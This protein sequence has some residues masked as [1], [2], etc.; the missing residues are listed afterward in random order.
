[1][2]LVKAL[3]LAAALGIGLGGCKEKLP[4]AEAT[5]PDAGAPSDSAVTYDFG[6]LRAL[7][8]AGEWKTEGVVVLHDGQVVYE[9]Y[10]AGFDASMRHITYSAS[11]SVGSALVGIAVA[12]GVIKL[13]ESVC[14]YVAPPAGS[15]PSLCDTTIEELLQM[16]SG[17]GWAEDYGAN[18]T[19]SNVLQMLYGNQQDMGAYV[20][21]QPRVAKAGEVWSYSSGDANLLARALRGALAGTDMRAWAKEKLFDPA[22]LTSA[23]F[24]SDRSGTLVF[25]SSCFMTPRDMARFGQLYL[26][27]GMNGSTRVLPAGWVAYTTT[28]ARPVATPRSRVADAAPGDTGGSYGASFWLNA[29]SPSAPQDTW[30]YPD[31]P[32]DAYSAEGHW[33]QKIFVVP[34][35]RLVI[36][37]VGNDRDKIFDS[38]PMVGAAVA[39]IDRGGK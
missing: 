10:A 26:D 39:S 23:I 22:G 34:S 8:F 14:T 16:T 6:A 32:P 2:D 37:R 17:L 12:D 20:A 19:T 33:G 9:E 11:K 36:A 1:V 29:A 5:I 28:P 25:S 24:E 30:A 31:A 27:D 18:P 7:L 35:R 15:D 3:F 21:A 13:A 4:A 38:G